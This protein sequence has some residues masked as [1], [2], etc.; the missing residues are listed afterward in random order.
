MG[1]FSDIQLVGL[2]KVKFS[3]NDCLQVE[4]GHDDPLKLIQ[5]LKAGFNNLTEKPACFGLTADNMYSNA[6]QYLMSLH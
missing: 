4:I 3:Y 1:Y 2:K 5:N 6:E